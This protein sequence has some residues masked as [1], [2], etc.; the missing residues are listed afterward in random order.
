M[1]VGMHACDSGYTCISVCTYVGVCIH[2]SIY[3]FSFPH[4]WDSLIP[5]WSSQGFRTGPAAQ[6][7]KFPRSPHTDSSVSVPEACSGWLLRALAL[8]SCWAHIMPRTHRVSALPGK[9]C[10]LFS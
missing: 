2:V 10:N 7:A 4:S 1:C 8:L 5:Y 9:V 3:I 6:V